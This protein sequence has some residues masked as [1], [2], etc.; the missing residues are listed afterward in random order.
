MKKLDGVPDV[1]PGA[2]SLGLESMQTH[3]SMLL[4]DPCPSKTN[5]LFPVT[6]T[7]T[8]IPVS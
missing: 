6:C 7:Y 4:R 5:M 2:M 8:S 1:I 3:D